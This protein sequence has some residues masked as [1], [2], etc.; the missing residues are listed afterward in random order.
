MSRRAG[1]D[2]R[3]LLRLG[4]IGVSKDWRRDINLSA[5]AMIARKAG[6]GDRADRAHR[7]MDRIWSEVAGKPAVIAKEDVPDNLVVWQ[8]AEDDLAIEQVRQ[9]QGG[10]HP[11]CAEFLGLRRPSHIGVHRVA[12]GREVRRHRATHQAK[13]YKP[14]LAERC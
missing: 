10:Y 5:A 6:S 9:M 2:D 3:E 14:D 13:A 7:D 1:N 4:R 8:H 11:A 12:G